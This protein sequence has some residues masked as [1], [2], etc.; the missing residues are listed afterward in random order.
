MVIAKGEPWG[1]RVTRPVD[2][3]VAA[4]D[5]EL[6]ELIAR[7][8]H[9][10]VA[11]SGGDLHRTL[12]APAPVEADAADVTR[13]P[14]DAL[15]CDLDGVEHLA[16][17]HVVARRSG[18]TGWWRGG[19]YGAF[20]AQYL[21]RW[22]VAPR[23]HP[24]DGRLDVV[25][26]AASMPARQRWAASRR[27]PAGTHVPHPA[28]RTTRAGS[29]DWTFDRPLDVYVDGVRHRRVRSVRVRVVPDAHHLHV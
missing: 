25:E 16:V 18:P 22:D 12:G 6:A 14:I 28:I 4:S 17:A 13:I 29:V 7:G 5:A 15:L 2:L 23:S 9:V 21:G 24:N 26:V 11:V 3:V 8:P 27:A 20:N 1:E 10:S 19:L